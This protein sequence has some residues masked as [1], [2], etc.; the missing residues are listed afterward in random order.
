MQ[1][2][3]DKTIERKLSNALLLWNIIAG[4]RNSDDQRDRYAAVY[5]LTHTCN[6]LA[7]LVEDFRARIDDWNR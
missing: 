1:L 5:L 6:D 7:A 3:D 4:L 2:L